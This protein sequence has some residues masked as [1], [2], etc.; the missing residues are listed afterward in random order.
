VARWSK[1]GGHVG[2]TSS[3]SDPSTRKPNPALSAAE[4][5]VSEVVAVNPP[6]TGDT[7]KP[8]VWLVLLVVCAAALVV[9]FLV[10]KKQ[11]PEQNGSD[12]SSEQNDPKS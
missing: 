1:N 7:A 6:D 8:M 12:S 11:N 10:K 2:H 3:S 9:I 4:T 5:E